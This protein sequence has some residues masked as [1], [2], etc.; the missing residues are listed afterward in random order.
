MKA[1]S[2][3]TP[4][5]PNTHSHVKRNRRYTL[6]PNTIAID[7][8]G[9]FFYRGTGIGTY[10]WQLLS[11]LPGEIP[12]LEIFLPGQEYQTMQITADDVSLDPRA[13]LWRQWFLPR[14]I[15][16]KAVGLYHVPQN[17]LGLPAE[18][19]CKE[20]VTIHDLIP[21]RFPETV[22]RG[23]LKEFLTEMPR[24]LERSDGVI[25]VS[26]CSKR[27]I[28]AIFNYPE[29]R[30][31]VIHEAPEP[32]YRP[33]N[34]KMT[35]AFLAE[36]YG[37]YGDYILYIGGFGIRKNVKALINAFYL[38]KKEEHL[39]LQL[40]LPGKRNRD[41]D[42][43]DQLAAALGLE[44]DIIFPDYVPVNDLPYFYN[45]AMMMV[46]PSFYEGFGLPPLEAMACGTPVIA[47]KTSSL[48]EILGDAVVWCNP[49]DATDIAANI[50]RL[51]V[52]SALRR[53]LSQRGT[54]KAASYSW[55]KTA[56][57]TADFLKSICGS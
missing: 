21:Y 50:H 45:G 49:L 39:P 9:A 16:E 47:A 54:E 29:D 11:R 33:I 20:T 10:T 44:E 22:G 55:Q 23:Y 37:V 8:R 24:V 42:A 56:K 3:S 6:K 30:I 2:F 4:N 51:Y 53:R 48:P 1:T 28:T 52:S 46:Y 41:F 13:D 34:G 31:R 35:K 19:R 18:K 15:K 5:F 36:K 40:V 26:Q 12:D 38:L 7:G 43:L 27:D 25:T 57:E 17:G 14:A 32:I